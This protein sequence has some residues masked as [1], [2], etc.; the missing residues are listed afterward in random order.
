MWRGGGKC[1][2]DLKGQLP[3]RWFPA[4]RRVRSKGK[5]G[6]VCVLTGSCNVE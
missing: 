4:M 1:S 5:D 3:L 6:Y 2:R